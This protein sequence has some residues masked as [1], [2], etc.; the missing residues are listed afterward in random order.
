VAVAKAF[1]VTEQEIL[2]K[3]RGRELDLARA[4]AYYLA[5]RVV[6]LPLPA[7]AGLFGRDRV[8]LWAGIARIELL[9]SEG[10]S[11]AARLT[12]L[13]EELKSARRVVR[14][15]ARDELL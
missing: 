11:L 7:L 8:T 10:K 12:R 14:P 6:G 4:I 15:R 2:S 5:A 13:E 3:E 1:A 9:A